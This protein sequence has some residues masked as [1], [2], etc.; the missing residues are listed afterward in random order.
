MRY[1]QLF[2]EVKS[3]SEQTLASFV[4]MGLVVDQRIGRA[5]IISLNRRHPIHRELRRFLIAMGGE[6]RKERAVDLSE[7]VPFGIDVLFGRRLRTAALLALDAADDGLD[8]S[9]LHRILPEHD[10]LSL[11]LCLRRF[12]AIGLLGSRRANGTVRYDFNQEWPYYG[13]LR[14]L[15]S[16]IN[17]RW[18]KLAA[19][20]VQVADELAPDRRRTK[21]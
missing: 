2:A 20:A 7:E 8:V 16:P 21:R 9:M 15:L 4:E 10:R 6:P 11:R 14:G 1:A 12:K 3:Q 17:N 19:H 5:R 18:P 13:A